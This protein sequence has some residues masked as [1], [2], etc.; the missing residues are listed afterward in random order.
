MYMQFIPIYWPMD[1][2]HPKGTSL[3]QAHLSYQT[4]P[5]PPE[6][7]QI[8]QLCIYFVQNKS[9]PMPARCAKITVVI[10]D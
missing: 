5:R 6:L 1:T 3:V 2:E 4:M 10:V 7:E 9:S 8:K